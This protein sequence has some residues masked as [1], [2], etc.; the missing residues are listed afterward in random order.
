MQ[1]PDILESPDGGETVYARKHGSTERTMIYQSA[2]ARR[3]IENLQ[4][5]KLWDD[6]HR[7]RE[8]D[9]VLKDM[10]DRIEVYYTLKNSP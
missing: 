5:T 10:L 1:Q 7:A 3:V 2:K 8:H 6:I 9:A 4:R